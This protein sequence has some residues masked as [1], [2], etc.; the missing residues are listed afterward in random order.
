MTTRLNPEGIPRN[1]L[2]YALGNREMVAFRRKMDSC[3]L[4]C[5]PDVNEAGLCRYCYSALDTPEIQAAVRW[6]S[7]VGP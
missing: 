6:T 2:M 3:F 7:G 5:R 4:C 1:Q